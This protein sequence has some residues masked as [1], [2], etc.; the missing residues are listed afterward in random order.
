MIEP[1]CVDCTHWDSRDGLAGFCQEIT[2]YLLGDTSLLV[3]G[4]ATCRTAASGRCSR[5]EPSAEA[6]EEEAAMLRHRR[7]LRVDAGSAYPASLA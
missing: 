2:E 5:F 7:D 3:R 6:R 1:R 4:L